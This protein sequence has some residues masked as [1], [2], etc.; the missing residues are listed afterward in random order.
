MFKIKRVAEILLVATRLGMISFG[1]PVAHIGYFRDEY[2]NRR[3]WLDE[4]TY[5]DIV[6]LCQ[7]L[8]GPTSSQVGI[9]I[10]MYMDTNSI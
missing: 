1:G 2:V 4:E 7:V 6:S 3:G 10:G 8:P 9:V 5:L